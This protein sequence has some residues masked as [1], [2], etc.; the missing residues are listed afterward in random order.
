MCK[1]VCKTQLKIECS[2]K[3]QERLLKY[4]KII[5][6][7]VVSRVLNTVVELYNNNILGNTLITQCSDY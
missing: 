7:Q 2:T 1:L 4:N 5:L 3:N 6:F